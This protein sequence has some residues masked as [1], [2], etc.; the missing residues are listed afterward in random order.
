MHAHIPRDMPYRSAMT[1]PRARRSAS[2]EYAVNIRV[3]I[4][5]RISDV[6][7]HYPGSKRLIPA[8]ADHASFKL[9]ID[10]HDAPVGLRS[11]FRD[12]QRRDFRQGASIR[13]HG[14]TGRITFCKTSSSSL[15]G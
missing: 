11:H 13:L 15:L 1:G 3:G 2:L 14:S 12:L 5:L 8:T 6:K 4:H 9:S 10:M 7:N